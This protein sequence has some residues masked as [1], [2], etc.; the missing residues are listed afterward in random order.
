MCKTENK[1]QVERFYFQVRLLEKDKYLNKYLVNRFGAC[2]YLPHTSTGVYRN[3]VNQ[4]HNNCSHLKLR[5]Y[6][7]AYV[8][9]PIYYCC[10]DPISWMFVGVLDTPLKLM[11]ENHFSKN[12]ENTKVNLWR[13][14]FLV[15]LQPGYGYFLMNFQSFK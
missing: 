6:F 4:S 2:I 14:L 12:I 3:L 11:S 1:L 13:I 15:T 10:K 8:Y 7:G 5:C 9:L